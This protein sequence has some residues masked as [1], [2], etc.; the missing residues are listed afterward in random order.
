MTRTT[1]RAALI[2]GGLAAAGIVALPGIANA[3]MYVAQRLAP[4]GSQCASRYAGHQAHTEGTASSVGAKFRVYKDG[5]L[6]YTTPPGLGGF[7][8]EFRTSGGNFPGPRV[9]HRVRGQQGRFEHVRDGA[10][11]DGPRDLKPDGVQARLT[12]R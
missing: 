3:D 6:I 12:M 1:T 2:I 11:T 9:L 10:G 7:A 4:G 8:A 5:T